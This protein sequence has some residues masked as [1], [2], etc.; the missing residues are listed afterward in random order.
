MNKSVTLLAVLLYIAGGFSAGILGYPLVVQ[1]LGEGGEALL[2]NQYVML[3]PVLAIIAMIVHFV[4]TYRSDKAGV[5]HKRET[6]TLGRQLGD[7]D[8]QLQ[9][10]KQEIADLKTTLDDQSKILEFCRTAI[11]EA[12]VQRI[13]ENIKLPPLEEFVDP[14]D[15]NTNY[16]VGGFA[17]QGGADANSPGDGP[18]LM[19]QVQPKDYAEQP[20]SK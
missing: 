7:F 18:E 1:F 8:V 2:Q 10:A 14:R 4:Q 11:G 19:R 15:L 13:P 5:T 12:A 17:V 9:N 6:A 16:H 20:E 3:L